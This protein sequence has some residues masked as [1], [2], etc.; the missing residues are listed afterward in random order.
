[1]KKIFIVDDNKLLLSYIEKQIR[2]A[3]HE[4]VTAGDGLSAVMRLAIETPDVAFIDY[5]LPNINGDKLCQII[6]KME[7]LK[8]TY[9]VAMSAAAS[10]MELKPSKIDAN[11]VIAKG[12][13]KETTKHLF[14]AIKDSESPR[15]TGPEKGLKGFES[16]RDRQMTKELLAHN[17]HLRTMLDSIS[18]GIVEI[19][20]GQIVYV[21]PMALTLLGK[22]METLLAAYL[23]DLFE[24]TTRQQI[25]AI[26]RA[27][28]DP[29]PPLD[30]DHPIQLNDRLLSIHK[31]PYQDS[32]GTIILLI[33]D[34]TERIRAQ[35][36]LHHYQNH[37]EALV[38]ERTADLKRANEQLAQAQKM[39]ALGTIAGGV[40]HDLNNVLSG[41]VTYP[42]VLLMNLPEDSPLKDPLQMILKSGSKAAAIVQ[43]LLT[44]ARR[45][46]AEKEMVPVNGIIREYLESPEFLELHRQYPH[47]TIDKNLQ[48]EPW[49]I[50][51]SPVHIFKVMMNI[52]SNALEAM[53]QGGKTTVTT[54][55][56]HLDHPL[57]GFQTVPAGDYVKVSIADTGSGIATEDI[58]RIFEPFFTKKTLGRS[59]TGLGMAVVWNTVRDHDGFIDVQS[60]SGKGTRFDLYFPACLEKQ[61]LAEDYKNINDYCGSE[62]ILIIDDVL[63]QRVIASEMFNKLGYSVNAVSSGEAALDYLEKNSADIILLDMILEEGID[64]LET[65]Q[66]VIGFNPGQKAVVTSG[67]SETDRVKE[68]QRLGA[69][70]YVQKPYTLEELA[71]AVRGELDK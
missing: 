70:P 9:V 58:G 41:I 46:V 7:H 66:K 52:I 65:Y 6:R 53:P 43:D 36:A 19:Y 3:G 10:E 42:E 33:A 24:G 28:V 27:D 40:A 60:A 14:A 45:S 68:A 16:A 44:L 12:T 29:A 55:N 56:Q 61:I 71:M 2:N 48:E 26:M 63:E 31:L 21:N 57:P 11:A 64:G 54:V 22:P 17:R 35:E 34:I 59:G 37:L 25:E 1:M 8:H 49:N 47:V 32:E 15:G 51:G 20:Q 69:G 67:F 5:F 39:E 4:V 13:F 50:M 30:P 18:E 23:P 38:E 62:E